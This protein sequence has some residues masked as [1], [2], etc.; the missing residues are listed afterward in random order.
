M[1]VP[2][3][4]LTTPTPGVP[5]ILGDAIRIIVG[6]TV[7]LMGDAMGAPIGFDDAGII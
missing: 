3:P 7:V 5:A 4:G 6:V 1:F 2:K